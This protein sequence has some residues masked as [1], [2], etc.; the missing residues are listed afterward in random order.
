MATTYPG[1]DATGTGNVTIQN[2]HIITIGTTGLNTGTINSITISGNLDLI[3][4]NTGS[5]GTDYFFNTPSM[6]VTPLLGTISFTNKIDLIL[7]ANAVL[8]VT[9]DT[10]PNPDYYGLI[11]DCN[12]NQ[13]IYIGSSVYA[14]CNGGG[15]TALT[16]DEV[17]SGGGTLNAIPNSDTLV[18]EGYQI[19][20]Y[21]SYSGTTGTAVTYSWTIVTPEGESSTSSAQNPTISNA[22]I[23]TYN[24]TLICTT[25][26]SGNTYTNSETINIV[27]NPRPETITLG[28]ITQPTCVLPNGSVVLNNLPAGNWEINPGAISGSGSSYTVTGLLP[29]SYSFTVTNDTG[30]VSS[31]TSNITITSQNKIWNGS[32][33]S[34]WFTTSNWTPNHV[35]TATD[36]V[37][38]TNNG[39]SPI[40][41]GLVV[42]Y[43][44]SVTVLNS[45]NLEIASNSVLEVTD[46]INV[47]SNGVFD[48]KNNASLIQI[49]DVVNSGN[50]IIDR[51][52]N[53]RLLDYVYWSSPVAGFAAS[54]IS[55]LSPTSLIW[56]WLPTNPSNT[57]GFGNWISGNETMAIGRGYIVRGPSGYTTTHQIY[58]AT[59]TGVPNNGNINTSISR[60]SYSGANYTGPTTTAVT[61]NDDNWNLVGN[62]YPSAINAISFLNENSNIAGFVKLWTHGTL[63]SSA[64]VDPFYQDYGS[65]YTVADYITYNA[66]GSTDGPGFLGNIGAGQS[67]F[68]LMNHT[69]ASTTE[70]VTF[71][72]SMR[73]NS[74]NNAQFFRNSNELSENNFENIER[75]RIWLDLYNANGNSSRTLIGYIEGATNSEDR[76]FDAPSLKGKSNFELYSLENNKEFSI[77]GRELPF[78]SNDV[79]KLGIII[80]NTNTYS[81]GIGIVDGLFLNTNQN[82]YLRDN[83]L[84]TIHDLRSSPYSFSST[85]GKDE[86]RF[87]LIFENETLGNEDFISTNGVTVYTNNTINVN[88]SSNIKSVTVYDVLGRN[89]GMVRNVNN[90]DVSL[91]GIAKTQSTL[92]V[93]VELENG[94]Q[95]TQKVIF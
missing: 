33:S 23:G 70:N 62:P 13:D 3:G 58:T 27:V 93:I 44:Y 65:N 39:N 26:Y 51:N 77:Q 87:E 95:T 59:F 1:Q 50:I 68:V 72:N 6:T 28:T 12:H 2:G 37:T 42:A 40:I 73:G 8:F 84:N 29:D 49:N 7:P 57:N 67:F 88:A 74:L 24:A 16:F 9:S 71:N 17:M 89:L 61:E 83:L 18:C 54:A 92:V 66:S 20:L 10:S 4:I 14:Y 36:C 25:T 46:I 34:D 63:P 22:L 48:I 76:L 91:N 60:G 94:V 45:C 55:P 19:N 38:I 78:D 53:I 11:G 52:V 31:P 81:I 32:I 41:S 21:G 64:I 85:S 47:D 75:N 82:I 79:V 15:S 86:S 5:N 90:T 30:C 80:P 43:A 56:K 35:P 69:S